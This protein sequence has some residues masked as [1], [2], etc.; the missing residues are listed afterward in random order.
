[1]L[2]DWSLTGAVSLVGYGPVAVLIAV[3]ILAEALLLL[4]H[5]VVLGASERMTMT[6][7]NA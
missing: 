3:M 5:D 7:A 2:V 4:T 1:M 6:T